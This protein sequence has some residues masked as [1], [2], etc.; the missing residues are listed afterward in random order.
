MSAAP[1]MLVQMTV[2]DLEALV[3][4]ALARHAAQPAAD[5]GA[6][7]SLVAAAKRRKRRPAIIKEWIESGL[8]RATHNPTAHGGRGEFRIR[9]ADLD[10]LV[11]PK[12]KARR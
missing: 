10:A 9:V 11:E 5:G 6:M 4:R 3:D 8:L 12:A 1:S 2:A 7:L